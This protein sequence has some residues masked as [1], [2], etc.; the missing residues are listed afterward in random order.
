MLTGYYLSGVG[1]GSVEALVPE[2]TDVTK[3]E[4]DAHQFSPRGGALTC[5]LRDGRA[6]IVGRGWRTGWGQLESFE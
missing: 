6:Y 3:I 1:A 2:G 5:S 4:L